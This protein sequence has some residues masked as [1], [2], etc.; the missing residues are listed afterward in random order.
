[1]NAHFMGRDLFL[2][3]MMFT[4]HISLGSYRQNNLEFHF[5]GVLYLT[6]KK[7]NIN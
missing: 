7:E 6:E 5:L 1:M 3:S 4:S 2:N